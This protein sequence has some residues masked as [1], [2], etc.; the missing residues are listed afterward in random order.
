MMF[1]PKKSRKRCLKSRYHFTALPFPEQ[2]KMVHNQT[3]EDHSV[4]S[5]FATANGSATSSPPQSTITTS[6]LGL[7]LPSVGFF[8]TARTTSMPLTALPKTTC[9]PS[10]QEV[11]FTVIKN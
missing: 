5:S 11:F 2:E 7:S 1:T 6:L 10:S 8:S 4:A 3:F 9:L